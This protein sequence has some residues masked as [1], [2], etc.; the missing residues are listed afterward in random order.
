MEPFILP[1]VGGILIGIAA[2]LLMYTLGKIAGISGISWGAL[3]VHTPKGDRLW[4]WL[5]LLG[6]PL[7]ALLAHAFLGIPEVDVDQTPIR[8]A[9]AGLLVGIG[10]K[11]GSGCTSGHGVC[12]ISRFSMRSLVATITFMVAAIITVALTRG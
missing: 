1:T 8:A 9:V 10:V 6:I 2:L 3:S 7:G 12:G 5:F 4:R 11:L